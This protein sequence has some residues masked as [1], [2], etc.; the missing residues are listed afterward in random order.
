MYCLKI[1]AIHFD[2]S[3]V[4]WFQMLQK[5]R[6]LI[7]WSA[8]TKALEAAFGPSVF[9]CPCCALFKLTQDSLVAT[10]YSMFTALANQVEGISLS[11]L[12]DCLSVV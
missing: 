9:E 4:P 12:L 2:G 5:S 7:S 10:Y 6:S 8:L 1:A 11:A 3:V